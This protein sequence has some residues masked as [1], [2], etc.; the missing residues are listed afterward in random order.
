[1]ILD[2]GRSVPAEVDGGVGCATGA[3]RTA[4]RTEKLVRR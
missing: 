2:T 4:I 3:G 1:M